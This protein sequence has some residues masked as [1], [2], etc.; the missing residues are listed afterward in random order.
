MSK[1]VLSRASSSA[2]AHSS[3]DSVRK[4]QRRGEG[5]QPVPSFSPNYTASA[6]NAAQV[7]ADP[8]LQVLLEA[9]SASLKIVDGTEAVVY[10][11]RMADL[12]S[13]CLESRWCE[14]PTNPRILVV[15]NRALSQASERAQELELPLIVLFVISPQ[16]YVAHDRGPRR[17]DFVLRNLKWIKVRSLRLPTAIP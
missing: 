2:S 8:P 17:V 9:A 16:D 7:D 14:T 4:R 6:E 11:M 3:V 5:N 1:R 13:K 12:R 10:W 15:D